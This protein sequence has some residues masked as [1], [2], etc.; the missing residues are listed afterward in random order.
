MQLCC[1]C[2]DDIPDSA[3]LSHVHVFSCCRK[4]IHLSCFKLF[5]E[6]TGSNHY[7]KCPYCRE[8]TCNQNIADEQNFTILD[9]MY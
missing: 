9:F 4:Q 7:Y 6:K 3:N 5:L 8:K 2:L 1:I